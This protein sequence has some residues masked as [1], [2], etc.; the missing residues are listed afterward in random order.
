MAARE[1]KFTFVMT[2]A[3]RSKLERLAASDSRSAANWLRLAIVT[4]YEEKFGE[5]DREENE[6]RYREKIAPLL[7]EKK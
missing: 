5:A 6:Q 7:N 1:K 3:E 4:Q 2:D